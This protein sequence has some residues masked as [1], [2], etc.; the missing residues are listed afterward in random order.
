MGASEASRKKKSLPSL[1]GSLVEEE[2]AAAA[3]ALLW[4]KRAE[5]R[6][7]GGR[8]PEP[9]HMCSAA[10]VLGRPHVCSAAHVLA[11]LPC[12]SAKIADRLTE[13]PR[14]HAVRV[15]E[16]HRGRVSLVGEPCKMAAGAFEGREDV[17]D[18]EV[19]QRA[20]TTEGGREDVAG[21]YDSEVRVHNLLV[22]RSP[23]PDGQEGGREASDPA[24]D[25]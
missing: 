15:V 22:P 20:E 8:P 10:R 5:S 12:R 25:Q 3:A 4:Q 23:C 1:M 16:H 19:L 7:V 11:T 6:A 14:K 21:K 18:V 17:A 9:P 13:A 2:G 24:C